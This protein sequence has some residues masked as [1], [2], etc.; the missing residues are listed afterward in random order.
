MSRKR[1]GG[2]RQPELFARSTRPTIPIEPNHRLV[3]LTDRINWT[4]LLEFVENIR[5]SKVKNAAGRPPQLRVLTGALLLKATRDMTWREA[6]DLMRHYA[7]ARYL[8]GLTETEWTPDH[9]TLHDF[10]VLLGEDGVKLINEFTV[11]WA[12]S[13]KLADPSVVV[14]DTTAQEAA[15][16]YPNEMGLM[17]AFV[18][19]ALAASKSAGQVFKAFASKTV[20]QV[21]AA[22]EK[23]REYRLFAKDKSKAAKDKMCASMVNVIESINRELGRAVQTAGETASRVTK[24]GLVAREKLA[25]LHQTVAKLVPQIRYWLKTGFVATGK[26]INLHV[27]ELYAIVRGK[28]GKKVE[29]GLNWGFTRLRGGFLLARMAADRNELVDTKFAVLAVE[30]H[31]ALFGKAPRAYAYDRGGYSES[32]VTSIKELG[33]KEIGLAPRGRKEWVVNEATKRELVQERALVEAGI[34]AVKSSR[35]NFHR[36]RAKSMRMM[37]AS[38]QLGVLGF[39]LNKLVRGFAARLDIAV[40]G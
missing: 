25:D 5:L 23:V 15:I 1:S 11:K 40:A 20:R 18:T 12:V 30:D 14:G 10:A 34:G 8:C 37:G 19:S 24:Y 4:D 39:N 3:L 17:A 21:Q 26:I 9:T 38:G 35:Y 7:P 16:P 29:F 13:E 27:P 22:R 6:E 28:V 31:I 33:V 36:P 2:S 32:N